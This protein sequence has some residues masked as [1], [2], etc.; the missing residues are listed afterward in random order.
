MFLEN[1]RLAGIE[2][3]TNNLVIGLLHSASAVLP[4][5]PENDM[6]FINPLVIVIIDEQLSTM[7]PFLVLHDQSSSIL[8]QLVIEMKPALN[9]GRL[10]R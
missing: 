9:G 5:S 1:G 6:L 8:L 7:C 3:P 10:K 4:G 2:K